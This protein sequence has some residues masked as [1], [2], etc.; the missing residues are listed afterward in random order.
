MVTLSGPAT[1]RVGELQD[2]VCSSTSRGPSPRLVARSWSE[3][4]WSEY[5]SRRRAGEPATRI[6]LDL[7]GKAYRRIFYLPEPFRV[8]IDVATH[9]PTKTT[10]ARGSPRVVSRVRSMPGTGQRSGRF[11]TVRFAREGRHPR[12]CA[13]RGSCSVA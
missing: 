5:A 9:P 7:A 10:F 12:H 13:P 3:D 4:W 11:G 6:V 2:L 1:Y 8:V